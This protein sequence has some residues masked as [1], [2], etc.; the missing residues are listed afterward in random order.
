MANQLTMANVKSILALREQRWS[1]RRISRELGVHRGTVA[2]YVRQA[3]EG[4]KPAN[5]LTGSEPA[6]GP[7]PANPLTGS[8]SA[9]GSKPANPLT[10]SSPSLSE[11]SGPASACEPYRP[12][13]I[14]K[15]DAGLTAQRILPGSHD[16]A[17]LPG[18]LL[19]RPALYA[20]AQAYLAAAVPADGV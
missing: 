20:S 15:L 3:R 2:R 7:K 1:C 9:S 8:E 18:E 16:R 6:S 14:E 13:I 4:P 5:P 19:E 10:G 17:R 11:R 12:V